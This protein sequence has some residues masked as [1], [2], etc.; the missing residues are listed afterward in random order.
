M[1]VGEN[2][3]VMTELYFI[4][5]FGIVPTVFTVRYFENNMTI[6]AGVVFS[7]YKAG[8]RNMKTLGEY[9]FSTAFDVVPMV[10]GSYHF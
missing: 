6:D 4:G 1:R 3:K 7:L 5:D 8:N 9:V 2:L 10:S